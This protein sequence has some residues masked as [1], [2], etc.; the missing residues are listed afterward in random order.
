MLHLCAEVAENKL[1]K[2]C[3][4]EFHKLWLVTATP[5]ISAAVFF[6]LFFVMLLYLTRE[7]TRPLATRELTRKPTRNKTIRVLRILIGR[8][9]QSQRIYSGGYFS[10][11]HVHSSPALG[12]GHE[13]TMPDGSVMR[14][15][16]LE[17]IHKRNG[18]GET[19]YFLCPH[20]CCEEKW[21]FL[22][23]RKC[24]K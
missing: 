2:H 22:W 4:F 16:A 13:P 15:T 3:G 21:S 6:L 10:S 8:L 24:S 18:Q 5:S 9:S 20:C 23:N 12:D 14:K 17:A 1:L 11:R 19:M 7:V